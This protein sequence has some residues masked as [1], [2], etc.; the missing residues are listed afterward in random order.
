MSNIVTIVVGLKAI[1]LVL[2]ALI[3]FYAAR[4]YNRTGSPAL[5][6]LAIGFGLVTV[7]AI[8]AG[9]ID[10]WLEVPRDQA[11]AVE[12]LFTMAGFGVILYSLYVE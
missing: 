3:T 8:S 12:S 5:R 1:G 2:G 6:A 9:A 10:L 7:G 4:A 11:L